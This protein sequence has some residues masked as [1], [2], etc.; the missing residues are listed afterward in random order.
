M[1][2]PTGIE[3][4]RPETPQLF[5][6]L[7]ELCAALHTRV[8]K[9]LVDEQ[10]NAAVVQIPRLGMLGFYKNILM[11]G[12]PLMLTQRP[13]QM[14]AIL[15]HELG[16]LSG[17]HSKSGVWVYTLRLR[18][19][20]L[21]DTIGEAG[22]MF[23]ALFY[24]FFS[25]FSPRFSAYTLALARLHELEADANA[26]RIAGGENFTRG[27]LCLRV[28]GKFLGKT[29]WP[30]IRDLMKTSA[31]PRRCIH[32]FEKRGGNLLP[33]SRRIAKNNPPGSSGEGLGR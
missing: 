28:Y 10:F 31:T 2:E 16:H 22:S 4:K 8:D 20:K 30:S 32:S 3:V 19:S 9:V 29:F 26:V 24:I 1:A 6:L 25:W 5:A 27:M 14:K 12:L 33:G 18:W 13:L 7:D 15:A 23:F 21:L 11:L 17:N